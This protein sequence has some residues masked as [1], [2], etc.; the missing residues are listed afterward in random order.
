[1]L[2]INSLSLSFGQHS[3]LFPLV[4]IGFYGKR[5]AS[6]T[7]KRIWKGKGLTVWTRCLKGK[8]RKL[9][10]RKDGRSCGP[11]EREREKGR[12]KKRHKEHLMRLGF[13]GS[14]SDKWKENPKTQREWTD[15]L[16][17]PHPFT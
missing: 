8:M 12:L 1:M 7:S 5:L 3:F 13:K 15:I 11:G 17:L 16:L 10:E 6:K 4:N 9:V 14:R 2:R